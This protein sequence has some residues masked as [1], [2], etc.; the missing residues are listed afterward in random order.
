MRL[1][2]VLYVDHAA[3][4]DCHAYML[5]FYLTEHYSLEGVLARPPRDY[6]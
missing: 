2:C 1:I 3:P 5:V 6:A 4:A